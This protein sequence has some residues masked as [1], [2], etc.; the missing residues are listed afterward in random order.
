MRWWFATGHAADLILV[1]MLGEWLWLTRMGRWRLSDATLL[2][3]PGV[4]M[5]GALRLA[6]TGAA[7]PGIALLLAAS[8]PA[9]VLDV[10]RR[11]SIRSST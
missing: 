9:H 2:L 8:A 4:L 11:A 7:W 1:V 6:L 5:I 3:L 10:R